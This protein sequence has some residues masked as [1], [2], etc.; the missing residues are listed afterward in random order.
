METIKHAAW[1][2]NDGV[3][4]TGKNHAEIIKKSPYG[5]C[6]AGS[7]SGF[8]TSKG[9]FVDRHE[10]LKIAIESKQIKADL[11]TIRACGLLSE[12]LW[13]DSGF[14]YDPEKGYYKEE[15]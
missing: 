9:R 6:K 7:E 8:I 15:N 4:S 1:K 10:A 3:I 5:T 2:R 12:N 14:K 13:A 11:D